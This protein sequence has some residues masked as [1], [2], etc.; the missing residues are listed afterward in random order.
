[1]E[2]RRIEQFWA[3]HPCGEQLVG[4]RESAEAYNAFFTRYD[5]FR[6]ELEDHIPRCLDE[7]NLEGRRVLEVGLGLG[8]DSEQLI[9]RGARWT[10][11]D[12]TATSVERV[13]AR[14]EVRGLSY[15]QIIQGSVLDLPFANDTFDLI[16]SHGVL[17]HVPEIERAQAEL[18]RV[19]RPG[20]ELVV[21]LYARRSLNYL[22]S[23]AI[24]RRVGLLSLYLVT[25]KGKQLPGIY[26]SH[27]N[28]ARRVGLSRYLGIAEFIHHNTDG[29]VNPYS[30]VYDVRSVGRDF[31]NFEITR[32]HKEFMHAPPLPVH[33]LPFARLLG[34]HLWVHLRRR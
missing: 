13:R 34:W 23:I 32:T 27:L 4:G 9:R 11:A 18:A 33:G 12:L 22:V 30:K 10:G 3:D 8:A 14:L 16:Y 19:L 2:E 24:L 7:L 21:M 29:P 28:A 5:S 26:G 17:H 1:M 20:G 15:D 6:Y 31:P 25:P